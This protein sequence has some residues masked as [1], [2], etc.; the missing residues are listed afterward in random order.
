[1]LPTP[2]RYAMFDADA[3]SVLSVS[4]NIAHERNEIMINRCP[5]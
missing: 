4:A 3:I 1:V 2:H 5:E